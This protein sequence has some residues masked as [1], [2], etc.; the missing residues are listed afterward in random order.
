VAC[1]GGGSGSGTEASEGSGESSATGSETSEAE[2]SASSSESGETGPSDPACPDGDTA[3]AVLHTVESPLRVGPIGDHPAR[4]GGR[5]VN[6]DG[7][8]DLALAGATTAAVVWGS[9]PGTEGSFNDQLAAGDGVSITPAPSEAI[10]HIDIVGDVNGDGFADIG[11]F[12]E[13]AI[14]DEAYDDGNFGESYRWAYI[15]HGAADLGSVNL[16][17]IKAGMG[18]FALTYDGPMEYCGA[19]ERMRAAGD[20]NDDGLADFIVDDGG[21][22]LLIFGRTTT[23]SDSLTSPALGG[24]HLDGGQLSGAGDLNGDG[25]DDLVAYD[26]IDGATYFGQPGAMPTPGFRIPST[27]GSNNPD[28]RGIGDLNGDGMADLVV[29]D[30]RDYDRFFVVFGRADTADIDPGTIV[31]AG[32]GF[33]IVPP[34]GNQAHMSIVGVGDINGDGFTDLGISDRQVQ[35]GDGSEWRVYVMYGG[36]SPSSPDLCELALGEGGFGFGG[37]GEYPAFRGGAGP[38]LTQGR[39]LWVSSIDA[40]YQ[41][42]AP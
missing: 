31:S 19:S 3:A 11:V 21:R 18:G 1:G 33:D 22:G 16:A 6:G 27:K 34:S 26:Y 10:T 40:V 39:Q 28:I 23:A 24:G 5:D 41:V 32:H 13:E 35:D 17:D 4:A 20:V 37:S 42:S 38:E 7:I 8:S 30:N 9:T 14:C 36:E 29:E 15:V 25:V 2:S 12:A